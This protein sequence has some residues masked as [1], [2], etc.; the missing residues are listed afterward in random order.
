MI[1][2]DHKLI[3]IH[4][5]KCA[6]RSVSEIFNQRFD[7]Y[8]LFYYKNE[9]KKWYDQYSKFAIVRNPYARLVSMYHYIQQHRRHS[10]EQIAWRD[11]GEPAPPFHEWVEKNFKA[12]NGPF[13]PYSPEAERGTDYKLGSPHW[14]SPQYNFLADQNEI[15]LPDVRIFRL[16]EGMDKVSE[17]LKLKGVPNP[18][19]PVLN[20]SSHKHYTEYYDE[21]L[22]KFLDD[23]D[24]IKVDLK[25]FGY[26]FDGISGE[27]NVKQPTV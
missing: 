27:I 13:N 25:A 7:Q 14:F 9:Y 4:I 16:E 15:I 3:F 6:G 10:K 23:Y 17:W 22:I 24:F 26:N 8:T 21:R 11:L 19:I 1:T 18:E 5:P 2:H 12:F 20:T